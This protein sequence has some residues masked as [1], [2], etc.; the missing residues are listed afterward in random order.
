MKLCIV[1]L[2]LCALLSGCTTAQTPITE[3]FV[4]GVAPILVNDLFGSTR[5]GTRVYYQGGLSL[6]L[7]GVVPVIE[8]CTYK[9]HIS[10]DRWNVP[11]GLWVLECMERID[12]E[13]SQS[14]GYE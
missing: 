9:F 3:G 1:I 4:I 14:K 8:G 10:E 11:K 5:I 7:K 6:S 13:A 2:L 12:C